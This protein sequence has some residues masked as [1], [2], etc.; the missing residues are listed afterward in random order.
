[1]SRTLLVFL[2]LILTGYATVKPPIG[3]L[4]ASSYIPITDKEI[5][6][7][8]VENN[9][10]FVF[11]FYC[12]KTNTYN[13]YRCHDKKNDPWKGTYVNLS[14]LQPVFDTE[15]LV[16]T[17]SLMTEHYVSDV[18]AL[19]QEF[20]PSNRPSCTPSNLWSKRIAW[21]NFAS[22][23]FIGPMFALR[24]VSE[25][26]FDYEK[27]NKAL[28]SALASDDYASTVLK[29][30]QEEHIRIQK[31]KE[32]YKRKAEEERK[33]REIEE[34]RR[35]HAKNLFNQSVGK[36]QVGYKVCTKDNQM[37]YVE[38]ISGDRVKVLVKGNDVLGDNGYSKAENYYLFLPD[39]KTFTYQKISEIFWSKK[40]EWASCSHLS[41][42]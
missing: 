15:G 21:G 35:N 39:V 13:P 22:W 5:Y 32:N 30:E 38:E 2:L 25:V 24:T 19:I 7:R 29:I 10:K 16:C 42:F 26:Q 18:P 33:E 1:M 36:Y 4:D 20:L 40:N 14:D 17:T 9:G 8:L 34:A 31:Q 23:I 3:E 12:I 11:D 41:S 28:A 6:A 27:Y 37:G